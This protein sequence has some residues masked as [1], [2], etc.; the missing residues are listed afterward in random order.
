[1]LPL[2]YPSVPPPAPRASAGSRRPVPFCVRMASPLLRSPK[3]ASGPSIAAIFPAGAASNTHGGQ[4]AEPR[5][6]REECW[7]TPPPHTHRAATPRAAPGAGPQPACPIEAR[8]TPRPKPR[9]VRTAG[10]RRHAAGGAGRG[11]FQE[12]L[13]GGGGRCRAGA[14]GLCLRGARHRC[15]GFERAQRVPAAAGEQAARRRGARSRGVGAAPHVC[16]RRLW[17]PPRS[18]GAV[19]F[20][21]QQPRS[22]AASLPRL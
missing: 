17:P 21:Q 19:C 2:P 4:R 18:A 8:G 20:Q 6:G 14:P 13:E 7:A 11:G 15:A 16:R 5:N 1:M 3:T 9:L 10:Q 12:L 22:A